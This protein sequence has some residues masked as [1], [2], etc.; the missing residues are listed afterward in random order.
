MPDGSV[1]AT[2]YS[3]DLNWAASTILSLG[4]GVTVLAPPDLRRL[5][6]EWANE[7]ARTNQDIERN[8]L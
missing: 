6:R 4:P 3:P 2:L 8:D 7:I 1:D 5:V